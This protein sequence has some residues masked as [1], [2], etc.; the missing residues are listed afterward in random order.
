MA[1]NVF[2][3]G[4]KNFN[5]DSQRLLNFSLIF[6]QADLNLIIFETDAVWWKNPLKLFRK[7][8]NETDVDL[9]IPVNF[10][11]TNGQKYAFDPMCI[12]PTYA[13]KTAFKDILK[14]VQESKDK[15]VMDQ[16]REFEK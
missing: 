2:R 4:T 14:K 13:A 12:R 16:V 1:F 7:A 9:T 8:F 10:K 3:G 15:K 5:E 6:F 11:E